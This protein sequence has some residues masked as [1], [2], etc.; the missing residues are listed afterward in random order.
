MRTIYT[1]ILLLFSIFV[2]GQTKYSLEL[3]TALTDLRR[4]QIYSFEYDIKKQLTNLLLKAKDT[5]NFYHDEQI[6]ILYNEKKHKGLNANTFYIINHGFKRKVTIDMLYADV[7]NTG[8][9]NK[10][11]PKSTQFTTI[12]N[13]HYENDTIYCNTYASILFS[14]PVNYYKTFKIKSCFLRI[15]YPDKVVYKWLFRNDE[16]RF[17]TKTI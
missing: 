8:K 14:L 12:L 2:F 15:M 3:E 5:I 17:Y 4:C 9:Q 6:I 7:E 10:N 16:L 11:V 13:W 1:S